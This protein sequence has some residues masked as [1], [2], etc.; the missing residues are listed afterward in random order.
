MLRPAA[1][2]LVIIMLLLAVDEGLAVD[3]WPGRNSRVLRCTCCVVSHHMHGQPPRA[4][5]G[6]SML[7]SPPPHPGTPYYCSLLRQA[8]DV[9]EAS[10]HVPAALMRDLHEIMVDIRILRGQ[11]EHASQHAAWLEGLDMDDSDGD[12]D[13]DGDGGEG[14][15]GAGADDDDDEDD[16]DDDVDYV[17]YDPNETGDEETGSE[18]GDES[19]GVQV[20]VA[21]GEEEADG[22]GEE[23]SGSGME[24][25]EGVEAHGAAAG[26]A[27]QGASNASGA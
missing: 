19:E 16:D 15:E 9:E 6:L 1:C 8:Q 25:G 3:S 4:L 24:D 12:D 5:M 26:L 14:E 27:G 18:E 10:G 22:E 21:A 23:G 7:P 13:E 17:E 2:A 11:T 20:Q